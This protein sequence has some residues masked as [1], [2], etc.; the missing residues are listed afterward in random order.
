MDIV[1]NVQTMSLDHTKS[2]DEDRSAIKIET[3][4]FNNDCN[5]NNYTQQN[6]NFQYDTL[7]SKQSDMST[8]DMS[9]IDPITITYQL[10]SMHHKLSSMSGDNADSDS[11]LNDIDML[12]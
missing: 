12:S 8:V 5:D 11:I 4:N 9:A 2:Y 1:S 6:N 7:T 3:P 10:M